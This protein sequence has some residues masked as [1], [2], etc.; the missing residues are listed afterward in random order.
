MASSAALSTSG[1]GGRLCCDEQMTRTAVPLV[2]TSGARLSPLT[3]PRSGGLCERN[4]ERQAETGEGLRA[5]NYFCRTAL[6]GRRFQVV[7]AA[8]EPREGSAD[9]HADDHADD[10]CEVLVEG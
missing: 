5:V 2:I 8:E 10:R 1:S 6:C 9:H 4:C 7:P 3:R